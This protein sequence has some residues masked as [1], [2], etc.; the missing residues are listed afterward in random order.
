MKHLT[1]FILLI[2]CSIQTYC[3]ITQTKR[4]SISDFSLRDTLCPDNQ[5]Y[6]Y[7]P[8]YPD[9]T[10]AQPGQP[11]LPL[12]SINFLIPT[13]CL[14]DSIVVQEQDPTNI[15]LNHK[16]FPFQPAAPNCGTCPSPGFRSIDSSIYFSNSEYPTV[17]NISFSGYWHKA[18]ILTIQVCPFKYFPL[19]NSLIL[20]NSITINVYYREKEE[21]GGKQMVKMTR[22]FYLEFTNSLSKIIENPASIGE[23]VK[24]IEVID[25]KDKSSSSLP[26]YDYVVIAPADF[27]NI[28]AMNTFIEWKKKKGVDIGVIAL[29]EAYN[30]VD[31]NKINKDNIG[32]DNINYPNSQ[33][34]EDNAAKLRMYLKAIYDSS[35]CRKILLVGDQN[36]IP[37][38]KYYAHHD[39]NATP[40]ITPS[41]V[42]TDKYYADFNS[43]YA[44]D[45]NPDWGEITTSLSSNI[46]DK[47][48]LYPEAFVGR[49]PCSTIQE[50]EIWVNKLINYE[51]NPGNGDASYLKRFVMTMAD[52]P[53]NAILS[54]YPS[55]LT[56]LGFFSPL[57]VFKE[58]PSWNTY[59]DAPHDTTIINSLNHF[60]AGWWTWD[61]HGDPWDFLTM[62]NG[63]H[64]TTMSSINSSNSSNGLLY[65]S[66]V[67]KYGIINSNCCN[68]ANFDASVNMLDASIFNNNGGSVAFVGN[69]D[70]GWYPTGEW[71]LNDLSSILKSCHQG[72]NQTLTGLCAAE[73][74]WYMGRYPYAY[75]NY[76]TYLTNN[77]F[78]DPDMMYYTKQPTRIVASLSS[79][80]LNRTVPNTFNITINNFPS[81]QNVKFCLF[82]GTASLT[83]FQDT[84]PDTL[85]ND[86][87]KLVATFNIPANTLAAGVLYVTISGFNLLPFTDEIIVS[88]GC[89]YNANATE[90][91]TSS[92]LTWQQIR[93]KD[94][95]VII[96]SLATLTII[97]EVYFVPEAKLIVKP[98]G[99]LIING[100]K[101]G[102]SCE[103]L[104]KGVEVLGHSNLT[105][106]SNTNQ[107]FVQ[108]TNS[109][110][111]Q[112]AKAAIS[113]AQSTT[114]GFVAGTSGGTFSCTNAK[115]LNNKCSIHVYPYQY[116]NDNYNS[117]IS[118]TS[119][120]M[121]DKYIGEPDGSPMVLLDGI[122][123]LGMTG[124]TFANL[125]P[126]GGAPVSRGIGIKAS[127]S[128]FRLNQICTNAYQQPC[129]EYIKPSFT[130]LFYGIHCLSTSAAKFVQVEHTNFIGN[131]RG[132][133]LSAVVNPSITQCYFK[134]KT[135]TG[136][137]PSSGLYLDHCTGYSIQENSFEG[138]NNGGTTFDYGIVVNSSGTAPN[139]IYN[140]AFTSFQYGIAAQDTNRNPVNGV[141]LVCKCNDFSSNKTDQAVLI[142]SSSNTYKGIALYQGD[143]LSITGPAGNTF[144]QRSIGSGTYDLYNQGVRFKYYHQPN[145]QSKRLKPEPQL[146]TNVYIKQW[147]A[148]PYDKTT[149][150]PSKL[151][152]GGS[153]L[154]GMKI[155]LQS[156]STNVQQKETELQAMVDG[157]TTVQ[158]TE[159]IAYSTPSEALLLHD[160]LLMKSPYLSDTVMQ[161]AVANEFVL[162]NVMIRDI[163]VANPQSASSEP[164][165]NE[166]DK[167]IEPMP[168]DMYNQILDAES[169]YSPLEI[170]EMELAS[171]KAKQSW[172]FNSVVTNYLSDTTGSVDDSLKVVLQNTP[173]PEGRYLLA[174]KQM[175]ENDTI[176][177]ASTLQAITTSLGLSD[178]QQSLHNDY[179]NYFE[180]LKEMNRD[181]LP[182]TETDSIQTASLLTLMTN[183]N[184]PVKSYI[185]NILIANRVITYEEP[186]LFADELKASRIRKTNL[187]NNEVN[188]MLQISPNPATGYFIVKY[189]LNNQIAPATIEVVSLH[190]QV[191]LSK[192]LNKNRDQFVVTLTGFSSGIY[193]VSIRARD[194][195]LDN[196]RLI[197]IK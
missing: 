174:L 38:R 85:N 163:L 131:D 124:L 177:A 27:I 173:F 70:V 33:D 17:N 92:S 66:N 183:V 188:V 165:L 108:V 35:G 132:I 29:T 145:A 1:L 20:N 53:Q 89:A 139:E 68:V 82:Q 129:N 182:G 125:R 52:G 197:V 71:K 86:H 123:G 59:P 128:G 140:N 91:I 62:T 114:N 30:Y 110:S 190:G 44:V 104:W 189:D 50:F 105:Q 12:A 153:N 175:A 32:N 143:S 99:K 148:Y 120:T 13:S 106:Y 94:H 90:H 77:F 192:Q 115:F 54:T 93:F 149:S 172:L 138:C 142:F 78:G 179:L 112:D 98:G 95:D 146:C 103:A 63:D 43:D 113:T 162:P 136:M 176:A 181:T 170:R 83:T 46:G 135:G 51:T 69:T 28:P 39:P 64:G 72:D 36:K 40:P 147:N 195:V 107:G 57:T 60:P 171:L 87:G 21:A 14:V 45:G 4:F 119:F 161:S 11:A 49:V 42:I 180:I 19:S 73:W 126:P 101:L 3:Q 121:D 154:E 164:V 24:G 25:S 76:E 156:T 130:G 16:I 97:G 141:G 167:R 26:N 81:G 137:L 155:E 111:I 168:E 31:T 191:L 41:Y 150:C 2:I 160:E 6:S 151:N 127:N 157:G 117:N 158:T 18:Q 122:K 100:G 109:G 178:E 159:D 5:T 169:A 80:H 134:T 56:N 144:S 152:S 65:L 7:F 23:F 79:R 74:H 22:S 102:T 10:L 58:L 55:T 187:I 194:R 47:V 116:Q 118:R 37:V 184:E 193:I 34:I 8:G 133:Y 61:N 75:D 84:I 96:D 185:Q 186:Y 196:C 15:V 9:A 166:L 48:D 88:P 67:N